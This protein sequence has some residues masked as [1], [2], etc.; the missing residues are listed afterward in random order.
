M[1]IAPPFSQQAFGIMENIRSSGPSAPSASSASSA[2]EKACEPSAD[3]WEQVVL[4]LDTLVEESQ[5]G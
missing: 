2:L 5:G 4:L 3:D 1:L